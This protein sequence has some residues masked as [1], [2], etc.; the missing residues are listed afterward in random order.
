MVGA[1]GET[2]Y[3]QGLAGAAGV[4][5]L[6]PAPSLRLKASARSFKAG[7]RVSLSGAVAHFLAAP[8][9][10]VIGRKLAGKTIR[11]KSVVISGV[12]SLSLHHKD[13]QERHVGS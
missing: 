13:R 4:Y 6:G 2:S 9:T 8:R 1:Y 5:V 3:G 12:G 11:L 10:V 7:G